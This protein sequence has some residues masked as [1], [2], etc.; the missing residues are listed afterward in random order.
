ML[1]IPLYAKR[2]MNADAQPHYQVFEISV[3]TSFTIPH[4]VITLTSYS[5]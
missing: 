4:S 5:L 3:G 2:Y 1:C